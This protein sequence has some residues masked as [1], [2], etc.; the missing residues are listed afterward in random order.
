MSE[1]VER[2]TAPPSVA[3]LP[4]DTPVQR[5]RRR[6]RPTGAPPPLP[7]PL[8]ISTTAWLLF[9]VLILTSAFLISE[10]TPWLRLGDQA[11]TWFLRLLAAGRTPWLTDVADAIKALG[12]GWG[13]TVIGLSV[14]VLTM[15]FRR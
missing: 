6:R 5:A 13:V 12:S 10:R 2:A 15:I 4:T 9:T 1:K 11:N 7:H 3:G 8:A 14:V